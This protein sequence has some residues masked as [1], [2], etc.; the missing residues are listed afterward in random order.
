[1]SD[2][3]KKIKKYLYSQADLENA[4]KSIAQG[5]SVGFAAKQFNIP[6]STLAKKAKQPGP[7][8]KIKHR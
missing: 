8:G 6:K 2:Q 4:V 3:K 1:M 7:P 5:Q